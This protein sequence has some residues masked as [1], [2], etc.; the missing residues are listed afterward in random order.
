MRDNDILVRHIKP[1]ARSLKLGFV[2]WRCLR[3][4]YATWLKLQGADVKVR[5]GAHAAQPGQHDAGLLPAVRAGV[6]TEGSGQAGELKLCSITIR[7]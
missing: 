3:T 4:S 5:T 6:T 1:A 7:K 2:N